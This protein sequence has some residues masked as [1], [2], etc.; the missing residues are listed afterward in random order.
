METEAQIKVLEQRLVDYDKKMHRLI[1]AEEFYDKDDSD[2]SDDSDNRR[3][4]VG[5]CQAKTRRLEDK[6]F[7]TAD[8]LAKLKG[9]NKQG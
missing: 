2:D 1:E 5:M 6:I 9:P 8:A 7:R 3:I 4:Y